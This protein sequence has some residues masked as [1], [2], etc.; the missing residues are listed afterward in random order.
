MRYG[1]EFDFEFGQAPTW[2]DL[3]FRS[4]KIDLK[5]ENHPTDKII[6]DRMRLKSVKT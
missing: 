4:I 6:D 3:V 2:F 5:N 1:Y